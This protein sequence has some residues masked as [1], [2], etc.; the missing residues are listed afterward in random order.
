[1]FAYYIC[2]CKQNEPVS[3]GNDWGSDAKP[4]VKKLAL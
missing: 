2:Y 1:M 3:A 4:I